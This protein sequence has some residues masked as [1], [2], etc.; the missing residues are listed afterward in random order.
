MALLSTHKKNRGQREGGEFVDA[1]P[2]S[3]FNAGRVAR[4]V[5][6]PCVS[7]A[8]GLWLIGTMAGLSSVGASLSATSVGLPQTL[9]MPGSLALT[10]PLKQHFLKAPFVLANANGGTQALHDHSV[11][12]GASCFKLA[13]VS[14]QAEKSERLVAQA[15][16]TPA[17]VKS[18]AQERFE[19]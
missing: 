4:W 9:S 1:P 19:R 6:L 10:D 11:Q 15:K 18:K 12:C 13:R 17:A 5:A 16:P 8:I 14:S 7:T 2:S 3:S